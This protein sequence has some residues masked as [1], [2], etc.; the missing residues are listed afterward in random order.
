[1]AAMGLST[2]GTMAP[3]HCTTACSV[4]MLESKDLRA[5]TCKDGHRGAAA[6]F[7]GEISPCRC[8]PPTARAFL[9]SGEPTAFIPS[10]ADGNAGCD[11]CF[12][13]LANGAAK[14]DF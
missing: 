11:S 10:P 14:A 12:P 3:G 2:G 9:W 4:F 6:P 7:W 8:T 1:M 13:L 5:K